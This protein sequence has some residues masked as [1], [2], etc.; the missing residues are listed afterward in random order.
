[1]GDRVSI[2]DGETGADITGKVSKVMYYTA[3]NV[4]APPEALKKIT[5]KINA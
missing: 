3:D 5:K 1:M 2:P 4:P